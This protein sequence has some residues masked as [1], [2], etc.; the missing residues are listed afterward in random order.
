MSN[1][2]AKDQTVEFFHRSFKEVVK[3]AETLKEE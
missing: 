3:I 2:E 1:E